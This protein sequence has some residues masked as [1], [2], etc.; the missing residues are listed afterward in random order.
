MTAFDRLAPSLAYHIAHTLGWNGLRAVQELAIPPVLDGK[1]AVVLAP[2]AGGKTEAAFF[3]LLTAMDRDAWAPT[4]VLYVSPIRAL[5][6]DQEQRVERLA[7]FVGRRVF[8]W[9]GDVG[10][11]DRKAFKREPADILLTTPES[12]EVML[13]SPSF[14][15]REVLGRL[16]AVVIDEAHAFAAGDRGGH[17][18]A[19]LERL[20]RL[21]GNDLQRIGLSATVGNPEGLLAWMTGS[22]RRE[23]TVVRPPKGGK[24]PEISLDYVRTPE[25]AA[26]MVA[27]LHPGEKRLVFVDSRR[28]VERLG[29]LVRERG[30]ESHVLHGSLSSAE[31]RDAETAF[32]EG[33]NRVIVATSAL[34]LGIDVGDLDRVL[35]IDCPSTVAGFL[36]RLGRT[37][38]RE[39]TTPNCT[40]L[41]IDEKRVLQAAALVRLWRRGFVEPIE[42]S[43]R[44]FHLLAHQV[45]ALARQRSGFA[46]A[47][48]GAT[49]AGAAP[50][51]EISASERDGLLSHMLDA[52]ILADHGGVLWLGPEGERLYA[53]RNFEAL[54][55]VFSAPEE[56]VVV[57]GGREIGAVERT[58]LS[59][60]VEDG[61]EPSF[62]LGGK[63]WRVVHID[64]TDGKVVV[65]PG[66]R[67]DAPK[68]HG[69]PYFLGYEL[70]QEMRAVLL[71]GEDDP[72]WSR[73]AREHLAALRAEHAFLADALSPM[74]ETGGD[75]KWFTY[76]GGRANVLL[77]RML[78]RDRGGRVCAGNVAITWKD[79]PGRS[80]A[81]LRAWADEAG[82]ATRPSPEDI[83]LAAAACAATTRFSK[84]QPCLTAGMI[85]DYVGATVLDARSA[86]RVL[87]ARSVGAGGPLQTRQ[88]G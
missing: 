71:S 48:V 46:P 28:G 39:G 8:K 70:C 18:M 34:E 16:R 44:A 37:G 42:P 50:F 64:W 63:P 69:S 11:A 25:N 51:R 12:L 6:N 76:A 31:R 61:V 49:L 13:T 57:S 19:V 27:T 23:G 78:E 53:R 5:L 60:L 87:G 83:R 38:R 67:A 36:Q 2:T 20:G 73:R 54:Y 33:K 86:G 9:H 62:V 32:R 43:P 30:V 1:N 82:I 15:R 88:P 72:A 4:S 47:D 59:A 75:V 41:V 3:P 68:W 65:E 24:V 80:A 10:T 58:F 74:I 77:G 35:Q 40:F 22:S 85:E 7:S 56:L 29:R 17:L 81:A 14:P 45:L 66:D 79:A 26:A 52:G 55:A 84:F 21:G